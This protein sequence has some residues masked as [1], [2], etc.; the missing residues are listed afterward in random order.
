MRA[1]DKIILFAAIG[2]LSLSCQSSND[3]AKFSSTKS[4]KEYAVP[5]RQAH[6]RRPSGMV[7]VRKAPASSI[8][9]RVN[10][11]IPPV[12]SSSPEITGSVLEPVAEPKPVAPEVASHAPAE[13]A[14]K[15][16]KTEP[17]PA[18]PSLTAKLEYKEG[19]KV[20]DLEGKSYEVESFGTGKDEDD[21]DR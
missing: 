12:E 1:I 6:M 19:G 3:N 5:P 18:A 4:P 21:S 14:V 15:T 8:A 7:V 10:R 13:E 20:L 9:K 17:V 2:L 11:D 16:E